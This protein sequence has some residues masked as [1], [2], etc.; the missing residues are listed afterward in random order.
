MKK[1]YTFA[2]ASFVALSAVAV[3][4][5]AP[6][7]IAKVAKPNHTVELKSSNLKPATPF[8]AAVLNKPMSRAEASMDDFSGDFN[9]SFYSLMEADDEGYPMEGAMTVDFEIVDAAAGKIKINGLTH[10]Y[11]VDATINLAEGKMILPNKQFLETDAD[12]DVYFY[13][14]NITDDG[15][16]ASYTADSLTG[17]IEGTTITFPETV[18]WAFGDDE[19]GWWDLTIANEFEKGLNWYTIAEGDFLE[20]IMYIVATGADNTKTFKTT[21]QACAD[22]PGIYRILNPLKMTYEALKINSTSPALVFDASDPTD[23]LIALSDSGLS[24]NAAGYFL[25]FSSSYLYAMQ[26]VQTPAEERV[27]LKSDGNNYELYAKGESLR[28]FTTGDQQFYYCSEKATSFKYTYDPAGV[29]NVVVNDENAPVEFYNLQG[30]RVAN[31]DNGIYIRRQGNQ[32]T[33]VRF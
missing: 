10:G 30:I 3:R 24:S 22:Y 6:T 31:P 2:L 4:P 1:L 19:T 23:V 25:Y 12:G 29:E 33:K 21:I 11:T 5:I 9:W 13:F 15:K 20:N 27:V 26:D 18:I 14:M 17:T 16:L 32:A 8:E 28:M 7:E